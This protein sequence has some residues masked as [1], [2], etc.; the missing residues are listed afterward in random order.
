MLKLVTGLPGAGKTSNELWDF[1]H[2]KDYEGRPK[3]ATPIKGFIPTNHGVLPLDHIDQWRDL[4]EGS[5]ILCDEVQRYCGT[6]L[7][8]NPPDWVKDLSIHRH[9]GKD[10]IFL[11]QAP[12]L[13][14]PFARKLV[15]PHVNYHRPYNTKR[16]VRYS[17]ESVQ[18]D[19]ASKTARNT[20]QSSFVKTNPKVFEMYTSTVLDTHSR[21]LPMKS[22]I[23]L[24]LAALV[25]VVCIGMAVR[26][27]M[28]MMHKDEP[29]PDPVTQQAVTHAAAAPIADELVST[30]QG[31]PVWTAESVKPRIAGQPYTAPVYDQLTT[32]T[33]F[34]RVAAC[35]S[36]ESRG[37]CDCYTQQ[38]TPV[39]VPMS[40]CLVFVRHGSFD[41]WL[42]GR[43]Q[44]GQQQAVNNKSNVP[45]VSPA[46]AAVPRHQ[47]Q[48]FTVVAETA[49]VFLHTKDART[50][51]P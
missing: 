20:G 6:E 40:A 44:Q 9:S 50:G 22:I 2:N 19:P 16:I 41:P 48:P 33:D 18:S 17:W 38:A 4:P 15:Q 34:P 3:Y 32:P 21:R 7:G 43:R 35:M 1:L 13:L 42:S 39:D 51:R 8:T 47:G 24:A 14:H 5:V 45:D 11:T 27:T 31:K 12:G 25:A 49:P 46:P 30:S 23:I 37:T 10:L 26:F 29:V 36:S 28:R